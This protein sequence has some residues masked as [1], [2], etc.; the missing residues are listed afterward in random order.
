MDTEYNQ[1]EEMN[2][3]NTLPENN[4]FETEMNTL[5][6]ETLGRE[7]SGTRTH[8]ISELEGGDNIRKRALIIVN[9]QNCFFKGGSMAYIPSDQQ[10]EDIHNE[11]ELINRI[12][13]L[14]HLHE[15]DSDYFRS[16]LTG[17]AVLAGQ[18]TKTRDPSSEM[19]HFEGSY[20]TGSRKKYFFDS[21][22]YTQTAY[23]PDHHA[24]A[25]HHYLRAKKEKINQI[26][27]NQ[28]IDYNAAR[29]QVTDEML[30]KHYWSFI[31]ANFENTGMLQFDGDRKLWPDHALMDGSDVIIE[32]HKCY[33]GI[34]FHPRMSLMPLYRPNPSLNKSVYI[35]P[36]NLLGRGRVI[37]LEGNQNSDPKS[38][39]MSTL[40]ESTGLN[41]YLQENQIQDVYIV[42]V[43]RDMM[44]ESTA[45]DA[46]ESG[47]Y[48]N[49]NVIY[50]ATLSY[51]LPDNKTGVNNKYYFENY[52]QM[53]AYLEEVG[54]EELEGK[55]YL[56]ENNSWAGNLTSKGVKIINYRN[57][58]ETLS[59]A[60]ERVSCN[61]D[62]KGLI[63][64]LD[65]I[66]QTF[67]GRTSRSQ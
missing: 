17:S 7:T 10:R 21:V 4:G 16:G 58:L 45:L 27:T 59:P 9:I 49:V 66:F 52:D 5:G 31:N 35:N 51:G 47:Q 33:R 50:D 48:Q 56:K 6:G 57:I 42:G 8:R 26:M 64:N 22:I 30:D 12:N 40:N 65:D 46:A 19:E 67:T 25:S 29:K 63:R 61:L 18:L 3:F 11:K 2:N 24:F 38:A 15:E 44:V 60:K 37:W 34:A 62:Q 1:L 55:E 36:P 39:F 20:P 54:K 13:S 41:E 14:I 53:V 23:P 28:G 32:N 43:F